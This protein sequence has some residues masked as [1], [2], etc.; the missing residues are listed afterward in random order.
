LATPAGLIPFLSQVTEDLAVITCFY[1]LEANLAGRLFVKQ[2]YPLTRGNAGGFVYN[3]NN[4]MD[5]FPILIYPRANNYQ[6]LCLTIM[7]ADA[8]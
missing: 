1:D 6:L 2:R 7:N 8:S 5:Y 4:S 3:E